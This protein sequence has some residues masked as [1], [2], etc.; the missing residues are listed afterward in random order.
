MHLMSLSGGWSASAFSLL[1]VAL[2]N[3]PARAQNIDEG[4]TGAKL[5]AE[6]CASCHNNPRGLAK[7]RLSVTLWYYLSQHYTASFASAQTLAG[8]LQSV[9]APRTRPQ[10]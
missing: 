4:K 7:D 1:I 3:A 2:A 6:S 5:F 10:P 9:D 8:Y